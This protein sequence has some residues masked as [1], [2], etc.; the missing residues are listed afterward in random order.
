MT[1]P[2]L[3]S[4]FLELIRRAATDLPEDVE[5]ALRDARER[6]AEGAPARNA[7]DAILENV[8]LWRERIRPRSARTQAR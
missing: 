3:T 7:L 6:E 8:T 5:Q 2:D 4:T 1:L